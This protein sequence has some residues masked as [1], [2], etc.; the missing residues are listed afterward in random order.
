VCVCVCMLFLLKCGDEEYSAS[1][2]TLPLVSFVLKL[3]GSIEIWDRHAII[4]L[5]FLYFGVCSVYC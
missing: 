5:M 4:F 1:P 3:K 2:L